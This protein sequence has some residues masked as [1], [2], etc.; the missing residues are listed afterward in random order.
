VFTIPAFADALEG[1]PDALGNATYPQAQID[2]ADFEILMAG[3][4]NHGV[5]DPAACVVTAQVV[6]DMTVHVDVGDVMVGGDTT[7][8]ILSVSADDL[9]ITAAHATFDRFDLIEVDDTGTLAVDT[10]TADATPVFPDPPDDVTVLAAVYVPANVTAITD[11]HIVDK[12]VLLPIPPAPSAG[13]WTTV[14]KDTD[15]AITRTTVAAD[16]ELT[17]H[18]LANTEYRI[19]LTLLVSASSGGA[20]RGFKWRHA[21]PA[22][23]TRLALRWVVDRLASGITTAGAPSIDIA[24]SGSDITDN[25]V[26][27]TGS[28]GLYI[29]LEGVVH[30]GANA[31]EFEIHTGSVNSGDTQTVLAG[32][33]LEY[34]VA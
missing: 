21:G 2:P 13:V 33:F 32:S 7:A 30:N 16:S 3:F 27:S 29:K 10:G 17:F 5:L 25:S 15:E 24:Y 4:S 8:Q 26:Q 22:S 12:R 11:A 6:P 31:G 14:S 20:S 9:T 34:G 19:R 1:P 28:F 23:P 18:M